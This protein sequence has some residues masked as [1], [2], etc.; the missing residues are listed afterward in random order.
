MQR[1]SNYGILVAVVVIAAWLISLVFLLRWN[2]TWSNPF[3]YLMVLVQ[4]HLYTGLFITAHDAMHGTVSSSSKFNTIIGQ[5]CT[6]LYA[7]FSFKKLLKKHHEHHRYVHSDQDPD[8]HD[9]TYLSW[10]FSFMKQYMSVMQIVFM[11]I[12]FNVL[13]VWVPES[14]LL[15]FWVAPALLS[16]LQLFTFGT[17]IPHHGD[18]DNKHHSST[19]EKN[20]L[21]GFLSC[22]FFGYHYEHHEW[23]AIPWWK[24][25]QMK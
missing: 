19:L 14:N 7:A 23:P 1:A 3:V 17:W 13:N 22:Y 4:M 16:T 20:H 9:G 12:A 6:A 10:Y 2:F 5:I 24:L 15:L 25:W 18:H 8:Y 11:A 21:V